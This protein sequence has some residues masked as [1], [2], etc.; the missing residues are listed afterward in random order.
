V[1]NSTG[2]ALGGGAWVGTGAP[3]RWPLSIL[4]HSAG[5]LMAAAA[6]AAVARRA[7][8]GHGSVSRVSLARSP[9][10]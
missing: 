1:Q 4:D 8:T 6:L 3:Y 10:G 9:T 7:R 2:M 5:Y